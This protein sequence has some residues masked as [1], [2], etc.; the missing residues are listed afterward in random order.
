MLRIRITF[1]RIRIRLITLLRI[2]IRLI[3][4]LRIRILIVLLR[5][6]IRIRVSKMKRIRFRIHKT[7][8]VNSEKGQMIKGG[9]GPWRPRFIIVMNLPFS[10]KKLFPFPLSLL[11]N[12]QVITIGT[13]GVLFSALPL[14]DLFSLQQFVDGP[15]NPV[16]F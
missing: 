16:S 3:T 15:M 6:R 8:V 9:L 14:I 11:Q 2:R 12:Y 5:M 10:C 1:M 7:G 13:R 4:S